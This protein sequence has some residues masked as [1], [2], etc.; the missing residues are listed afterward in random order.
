MSKQLQ[1]SRG[2]RHRGEKLPLFLRLGRDALR[3][4]KILRVGDGEWD[5]WTVERVNIEYALK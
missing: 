1:R 4:G 2:V 5:G 3:G